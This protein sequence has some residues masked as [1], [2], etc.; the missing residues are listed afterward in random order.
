MDRG[1]DGRLIYRKCFDGPRRRPAP[2][3]P[4]R[5]QPSVEFAVRQTA[6]TAA[7]G[8]RCVST[9]CAQPL[10]LTAERT[11]VDEA[12]S[13]LEWL[14]PSILV[15]AGPTRQDQ[16]EGAMM[17]DHPR[18]DCRPSRRCKTWGRGRSGSAW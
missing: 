2:M 17:G 15:A 10:C 12:V 8:P 3:T 13:I 9:A 16:A 5:G 11:Q 6:C 7:S 1:Q 18:S 14:F 4:S